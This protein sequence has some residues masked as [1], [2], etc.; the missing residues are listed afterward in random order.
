MAQGQALRMIS[1]NRLWHM[2]KHGCKIRGDWEGTVCNWERGFPFFTYRI[3]DIDLSRPNQYSCWVWFS[4]LSSHVTVML[5]GYTSVSFLNKQTKKQTNKQKHQHLWNTRA[6]PNV[7]PLNLFHWPM[8]LE[9][10]VDG[11]AV[12]VEP[13]HRYCVKFCCC[14]TGGSRGAVWQNG[15]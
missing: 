7:M 4:C 3:V 15:V 2:E 6:F 1:L 10:N 13:S 12:D 11:M 5:Q 14:V 9:V 8:T